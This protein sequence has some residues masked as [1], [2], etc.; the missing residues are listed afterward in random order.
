MNVVDPR[1]YTKIA[2]ILFYN[3]VLS[4]II[5]IRLSVEFVKIKFDN[6]P[7]IKMW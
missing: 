6:Y 1:P 4:V 3:R 7:K 2:G 5:F